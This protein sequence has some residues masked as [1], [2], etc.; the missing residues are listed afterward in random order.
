MVLFVLF[1]A[2]VYDLPPLHIS[3]SLKALSPVSVQM[4]PR[5]MSAATYCPEFQ[6]LHPTCLWQIHGD[7]W[8]LRPQVCTPDLL[9]PE[10]SGSGRTAVSAD[11]CL[12]EKPLQ[13]P[14]QVQPIGRQLC[15]LDFQKRLDQPL[16]VSTIS[17]S[18]A[19]L[20]WLLPSLLLPFCHLSPRILCGYGYVCGW[21]EGMG[22]WMSPGLCTP[23]HLL[24]C[25][26]VPTSLAH[27]PFLFTFSA[28]CFCIVTFNKYCNYLDQMILSPPIKPA[29][30]VQACAR[31]VSTVDRWTVVAGYSH[32]ILWCSIIAVFWGDSLD[33]VVVVVVHGWVQLLLSCVL[34]HGIGAARPH[35]SAL[36]ALSGLFL[37]QAPACVA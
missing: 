35:L 23:L 4:T 19:P 5:F 15:V 28:L 3:S 13:S 14:I 12:L 1:K 27:T 21:V 26:C 17:P 34:P 18:S 9:L 10:A 16:P 2:R 30:W 36:P 7:V 20:P 29:P 25:T 8:Y 33:P 31:A 24:L 6:I 32:W 11:L 22:V 37:R